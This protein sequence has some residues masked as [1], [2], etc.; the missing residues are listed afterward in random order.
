MRSPK[1][2]YLGLGGI[3]LTGRS[4]CD[5]KVPLHRLTRDLSEVTCVTC[6]EIKRKE[7]F[8]AT[9]M[10]RT[11]IYYRVSTDRQQTDSQVEAI[12]RWLK[13][14]PH[15]K[16][17][18]EVRV[19]EDVASGKKSDKQRPA[20]NSIMEACRRGEIDTVV[21]YK[22]DRLGRSASAAIRMVLDMD[23]MGVAFVSVSQPVLSLGRDNPFRKTML[24][25]FAEIAQIERESIVERTKEGLRAARARGVR[26]GRKRVHSDRTAR[27][28]FRLRAEGLS[29]R[30]IGRLTK[31]GS[32][33]VHYILQHREVPAE[34][35][36]E[37]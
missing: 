10:G 9:G 22:L 23:D 31:I 32:A 20:L 34:V 11:A 30:K 5:C 37:A 29:L 8:D 35:K 6:I 13:E 14:T 4:I 2:H 18:S 7:R 3:G 25:A 21:V 33:S 12:E 36:V 15:E 26:L 17:P 27:E 1:I 28:V 24:A 19:F 16:A